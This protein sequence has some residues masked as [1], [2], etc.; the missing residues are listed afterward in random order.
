MFITHLRITETCKLTVPYKIY[1]TG[2]TV[3]IFGNDT[4][5]NIRRSAVL[6][7]IGISVEEHYN[8]CV[9]LDRTGFT[10]V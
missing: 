4:F 9:L 3:T 5:R 8:I 7:V 1:R 6:I 10:K 2:F